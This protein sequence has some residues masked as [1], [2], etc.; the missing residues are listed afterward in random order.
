M[1]ISICVKNNPPLHTLTVDMDP[2]EFNARL[3]S[4]E[5]RDAYKLH[6]ADDVLVDVKLLT[7]WAFL[8]SPQP[9]T[10]RKLKEN[11]LVRLAVRCN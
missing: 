2:P 4:D 3:N 11:M 5:M 7:P 9:E 1:A 10:I 6:A 8:R